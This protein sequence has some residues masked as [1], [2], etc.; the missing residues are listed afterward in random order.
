MRQSWNVKVTA[1]SSGFGTTESSF[2]EEEATPGTWCY[3]S[4]K[5]CV[6]LTLV[7][8]TIA[9]IAVSMYFSTRPETVQVIETMELETL[10]SLIKVAPIGSVGAILIKYTEL[11]EDNSTIF[12]YLATQDLNSTTFESV[13]DFDSVALY[14]TRSAN[15]TIEDL[16][17]EDQN[18]GRAL[19]ANETVLRIG[20]LHDLASP[21]RLPYFFS[22]GN[23]NGAILVE[24]SRGEESVS[25]VEVTRAS[26]SVI[27]DPERNI[28]TFSVTQ[29]PSLAPTTKSPTVSPTRRVTPSPSPAPSQSPTVSPSL[30]PSESQSPTEKPSGEPLRSLSFEPSESAQ[31]TG[32]P[33]A[34]PSLRPTLKPSPDPTAQPTIS[35]QPSMRGATAWPTKIPS[36]SPTVS[37]TG[38]PSQLPSQ[39][40]SATPSV[41]PTHRPSARPTNTPTIRPSARP[42]RSPTRSPII[43]PS[44]S[45]TRNP[46]QLPTSEPT[47]SSLFPPVL[48]AQVTGSYNIDATITIDFVQGFEN[49]KV[50]N[51]PRL[52]FEIPDLSN[53][54][55]PYLYLSKRPFSETRRR[56]LE[57]DDIFISID[58]GEDGQF[59]VRG[60]FDQF[61]DEL[62]SA[63]DLEDYTNGSWIVWCRPF[64]VWIGG[65]S[66]SAS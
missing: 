62:D 2:N 33:S 30:S 9:V 25:I 52:Q 15:P 24:E 4:R 20:L 56:D 58:S 21:F 19:S 59:N 35:P 38:L 3:L 26:F 7:F 27:V 28:A 39:Q 40:P 48:T 31:P 61:L 64:G 44:R 8:V 16:S 13:T 32:T 5:V 17:I 57:D 18:N 55:G 51:R 29:S 45:L 63:L 10:P 53:A 50:V 60:R 46:T 1:A 42:I 36:L 23:F 11:L 54:P 14:L 47:Q 49:G 43:V 37:P 22:P 6:A 65:G 41:Q 34:S 12:Y 66:I